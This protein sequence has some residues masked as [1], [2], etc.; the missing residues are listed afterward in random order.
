MKRK[1][2]LITVSLIIISLITGM[3]PWPVIIPQVSAEDTA[4]KAMEVNKTLT[5]PVIDGHLDEDIWAVDQLME[6]RTGEG[7]FQ[8][9]GFGVLW[10]NRYLYIAVNSEDDTLI[11]NG[12]GNW[13]EQDNVN[14]F[15]DPSQHRSSPFALEDMQLGLVYQPGTTT[16]EFHF[17]AALNNHSGKDEKKILRAIQTTAK[18]WS[19]EVAIPWDMLKLDP[20]VTPELAMEISV[21]DR[22]GADS[23]MQRTSYWSAYNSSSFWNDTAGYGT[24]TLS[25]SQPVSGQEN[26]V[27]LEENF[28]GY[29]AGELPYGWISDVNTGSNPFTVVQDTYGNG[30]IQFDGKASG[31]Q[32][33]ITAPVQWDNYTIEADVRFESVLDSGRWAAVMFRGAADGKHPYNQMAVRQRGTYEV[34]Y[35]KPDNSWSV[36]TAGESQPLSLN[37]DYTMKVRV[38]DNNV[39]E[40][41]KAAEDPQ[42]QMLVDKSFAA[43]LLERG[44]IGFQ[45]DQST[46]S[47]D[48]LKVSRITAEQLKVD[49]P[50]T[51]EALS[52]PVSVTGE[53]YYSD[54]VTEAVYGERMKLYS[55]DENVIRIMNNRL[56]P[57]KAGQATIKTV[58]YNTEVTRQVV[59]TPSSTGA[60]VTA[61]SHKDGYVLVDGKTLDLSVVGFDAE[62]SDF[63]TGL[64][65][66]DELTWTSERSGITFRDGTAR[67][68]QAG[69]Y[70]VTVQKDQISVPLL[71]VSKEKTDKEYVLYEEDFDSTPEGTLPEGWT[72][73]EGTT[74]GA[75]A[76]ENGAFV[77]KAGTSPDNPSRVLLPHYLGLFGDYKIEADVT[78]LAANDNA[79]WHS[80]MYRI[81]NDNYPY[82][83]MAVRKDAT[84]PN[85]IEMAERTP[86]NGWNVLDKGSFAEVIDSAKLYHYS[87]ITKGNR[88]QQWIGD[89]LIVNTDLAEAYTKGKIGF[90]ANGS[91]MKV[92]N[93]R[94]VLRQ[95]PLPPMPPKPEDDYVQVSEPESRISMAPSVI[96]GIDQASDLDGLSGSVLPATVILHVNSDMKITNEQST[97]VIGDLDTVL[98]TLGT[99]MMPAFYVRDESTVDQLVGKL[100]EKKL[101]DAFILSDQG[102]L[103]QRARKSYPIIRGIVDYSGEEELSADRMLDLRRSAT[104]SLAKIVIL[105]E[106]ASSRDNVSYLQERLIVV[107]S[108]EQAAKADQTLSIHKLI[109]S[110]ANGI[111]TG[112][113]ET[114]FEAYKLYNN[115]TTLVRKPYIIAHRGMPAGGTTDGAP[116]NTIISNQL[117]LEAGADFIENDMFLSK[118]GRLMILH[119]NTLEGTTNGTGLIENYTYEELRQ[120]DAN[121]THKTQYPS[122]PIPTLDEQLELAREKGKMVFAEIKTSTPEAVDVL[123]KLIKDTGSED[124]INVMSFDANQ[125]KR[126]ALLMPEMPSGLL[127]G[128]IAKET[129]VNKSIRDTLLAVQ[130]MNVT[131]N[132]SYDG[133]G[134]NVMEAAKHRGII[135]SPWTFNNKNDFIKFF[136]LGAYGITTDFA[137]WASDWAA[138]ITPEKLHYSVGLNESASLS[139]VVESYAEGK[140]AVVAPEL[141]L[142]DGQ[143]KV[144]VEGNTITGL[145]P[146]TVHVLMR[147]TTEID[148]DNKY[149]IYSEPVVLEV[150]GGNTETPEPS[151]TPA[152]TLPPTP[153]PTASPTPTPTAPSTPAPT[154][155]P[156]PA[157]SSLPVPASPAPDEG[158]AIEAVEGTVTAA[159]LEDSFKS[160]ERV[161]VRFSGDQLKVPAAGLLEA[162]GKQGAILNLTNGNAT[163]RIPLSV[164]KLE[165]LAQQ[166]KVN[167]AELTILVS[168]RKLAGNEAGQVQEAI[169]MTGGMAVA[170]AVDFEVEAVSKDGQTVKVSFGSNY[171]SREIALQ[172][173][174]DKDQMTAVQ[175]DPQ[176]G[177]V[178]FVPAIVAAKDGQRIA[179]IKSMNNGVYSIIGNQSPKS[180]KD[181]ANH[182][183]KAEVELLANKRIVDGV[184]EDQFEGNRRI[185]RSEFTAL[186]VRSL[187]LNKGTGISAGFSDVAAAAWYADDVAAG[188]AAG[189][190][191]GY[192]DG[193][194]APEAFITREE[195]AAIM[196]RA[197]SRVNIGV[198]LA[199]SEQD[200]I[201]SGYKDAGLIKWSK[202]DMAAAIAAG[203]ISGTTADTLESGSLAT[204]AQSAVMIQRFLVTAKFIN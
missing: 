5:A 153:V 48:N 93:V 166:L 185:T 101:E 123:V 88:V 78:S 17:G 137:L 57:V 62:L 167:K 190:I 46:V 125:L 170:D 68:E 122:L 132:T 197:L 79:R 200:V 159:A 51:V 112:A 178:Q 75:A 186:M 103:V 138:S 194:F 133:L 91:T 100:K 14:I 177:Q 96:T 43:D 116:E 158:V 118:D 87:V 188:A 124:L 148:A 146:G 44:K 99:R 121:Q 47:F 55:S 95:E 59:V 52:G 22:Y 179:T 74:P 33:R 145:Q 8:D 35:R 56:Y 189:L 154:A 45:A 113:P 25:N 184:S 129:N 63:S 50:E 164:F 83:Q 38:F 117:G 196:I 199:P 71:L 72:R 39:K 201:L 76:V 64:L 6:A 168:M 181:M 84:V 21:T 172:S 40:Y 73:K 139:A 15:L 174:L 134:K 152:P 86:A 161:T 140:S 195:Q 85:G 27:L 98:E 69:V 24:L 128:G 191:S 90:Q 97:E 80:I 126:L 151:P 10:D 49:I 182:W 18:G 37:K 30:R 13:W 36:M 105:P 157:A 61:M 82:Y 135:I 94:V 163:Y 60:Q 70:P 109:A 19:L 130:S 162:A 81:Q 131:F 11:H 192:A 115:E 187:G 67:I 12:S 119:N 3:S 16:P 4:R 141:V 77:M 20:L 169:Q 34:S 54:G 165:E 171:I 144:A 202:A 53:V 106:H 150:E 29:T 175:V 114:A 110:G 180:F 32:A 26:P 31:K 2:R 42:Y 104:E 102:K 142:I 136:K 107:W 149:D 203:L 28:D 156:S 66:G 155:S 7:D 58:Y 147:Y 1:L 193:T 204:R 127:T 92:D 173:T 65:T 160:A 89:Q 41:I 23:V 183:A 198:Q 176:T 111:L 143:N 9:S 120:L 108:K